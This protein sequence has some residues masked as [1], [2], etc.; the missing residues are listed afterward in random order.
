MEIWTDDAA[1]VDGF[2]GLAVGQM[3]FAPAVVLRF[4]HG[5]LLDVSTEFQSYYDG[6]IAKLRADLNPQALRD[7][8][9]SDGRLPMP[10]P[11]TVEAL[12]RRAQLEGVK[13]K[14]LEI[15]WSYLYSGRDEAGWNALAELWPAEDADRVRAAILSARARG[16]RSQ[17]DGVST[18]L[19]PARKNHV[20]IYDAI[21]ETEKGKRAVIPP[22]PILLRRPPPLGPA[23][24]GLATGEVFLFLV[25]D[26]AG[27]VRSAEPAD[28]AK[29]FDVGLQGAAANWKFIPAFKGEQAVACRLE[30]VVTMKR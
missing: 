17:V 5:K 21:N 29:W 14:V 25:V 19:A 16:I 26:S 8:K 23:Q 30:F 4:T 22:Q 6:K 7:F 13:I 18:E 3:D 9:S 28:D 15:V 1:A 11:F 20:S 27:K 12:H 24:E 2:D 10:V